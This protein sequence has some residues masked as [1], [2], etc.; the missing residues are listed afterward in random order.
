MYNSLQMRH[1]HITVCS[2]IS[3]INYLNLYWACAGNFLYIFFFWYLNQHKT[4]HAQDH[5]SGMYGWWT[6]HV[7]VLYVDIPSCEHEACDGEALTPVNLQLRI[8]LLGP[9]TLPAWALECFA[10]WTHSYHHSFICASLSLQ[11]HDCLSYIAYSL[12]TVTCDTAA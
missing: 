3:L 7:G 4:L 6:V 5:I 12:A 10:M 9:L 11:Y 2:T 8:C 1:A